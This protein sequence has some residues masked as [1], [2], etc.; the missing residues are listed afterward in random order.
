MTIN[1][2]TFNLI[3][4]LFTLILLAILFYGDA[5]HDLHCIF[6]HGKPF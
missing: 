3:F 1:N 2:K 4:S 6:L 5:R